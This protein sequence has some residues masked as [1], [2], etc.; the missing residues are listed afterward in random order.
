MEHNWASIEVENVKDDIKVDIKVR[1]EDNEEV[2]Q[3]VFFVK[4]DLTFRPELT[5]L[6]KM[7]TALHFEN[8]KVLTIN[9]HLKS[10]IRDRNVGY[11]RD[12]GILFALIISVF[13]GFI[14]IVG[15]VIEISKKKEEFKIYQTI[16]L[17]RLV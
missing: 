13:S 9:K 1:N 6:N 10:W 17:E 5:K 14:R 2:Q 15:L 3:K 12:L 8:R 11:I 4:K 7:C 16:S